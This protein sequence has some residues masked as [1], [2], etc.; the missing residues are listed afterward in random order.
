[1]SRARKPD[2]NTAVT[3]QLPEY[4]RSL[5]FA[6]PC[7][8]SEY[9]APS[10]P[11]SVAEAATETATRRPDWNCDGQTELEAGV[12][13]VQCTLTAS[14]C[15]ARSLTIDRKAARVKALTL[16]AGVETLP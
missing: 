13:T 8:R 9:G 5:A 1:M 4:P 11:Q 2:E 10:S 3:V 15:R 16:P 6:R 14:S 7:Q 12:C